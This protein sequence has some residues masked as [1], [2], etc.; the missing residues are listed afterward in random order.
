MLSQLNTHELRALMAG[1]P[2][3]IGVFPIDSLP[4]VRH[5][6]PLKLIVNLDPSTQPGSHWVAIYRRANG[7]AYYF[8]TFGRSPP[9][10]IREWLAQ[11]SWDW[12]HFDRQIQGAN[13]SVSCGYICMTFLKKLT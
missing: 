11:N 10:L 8:D 6:K 12:K 3:F 7:Q 4:Q 2:N 1:E 9:P 13:D 5:K